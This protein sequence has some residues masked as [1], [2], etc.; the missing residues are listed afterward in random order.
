MGDDL[1]TSGID[2]FGRFRS[3]SKP[4]THETDVR[5]LFQLTRQPGS[6]R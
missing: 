2:S 3:I 5:H 4:W 6:S 1:T